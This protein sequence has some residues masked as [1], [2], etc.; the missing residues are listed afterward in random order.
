M[1]DLRHHGNIKNSKM[2]CWRLEL[3]QY[4]FD[5]RHKPGVE[6]DAPDTFSRMCSA[7]PGIFLLELHKSLG[8][9]GY[10]RFY[11]FIRQRNLPF[12]SAETK[13]VCKSCHACPEVKP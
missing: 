2:L 10:A 4:N 8:H 3:G 9:P 12:S 13:T 1:F 5:I 11:H 7:A 6:H